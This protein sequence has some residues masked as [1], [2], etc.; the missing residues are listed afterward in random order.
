MSR[1]IRSKHLLAALAVVAMAAG[2]TSAQGQ[3]NPNLPATYGAIKLKAGFTPDPIAKELQAGGEIRTDLGGVKAHVAMAPDFSVDYAAG[4][5]PLVFRVKSVG[6]T[7]LLVNLPD[8]TW[9]ADDD[10]GGGLDPMIRIAQP[11]SGRYDIYVGTFKKEILDAT[12]FISERDLLKKPPVASNPNLPECHVVSAGVDNYRTQ[13]K[14][15]GCLNDAR[16]TAAAF[17]AQTGTVFRDV[18]VRLLLDE[19]ASHGAIVKSFQELTRQGAAGDTM[20]LFLSG[21][22]ARTNGNKGPTWF[23]LP[24]DFEPRQFV[25]TA[26]TD[27]QILDIADQLASQKKNVA[28]IIDACFVGQLNATAQPYLQRYQTPNQ[29][30]IMLML[31]SSATQESTALGNYSAY[32]KAFADS[33]AGAGDLNRDAKIT[34]GEMQLYTKKRTSDLLLAARNKNVQDPIVTWSPSLSKDTVVAYADK[35]AAVKTPVAALPTETP[36]RFAGEE[37]LA[38]YGNLSFAMYSNGRVVMADAKST[39]HGI[40]RQHGTQFTLSFSDGAVVYTGTLDGAVL[41]GTA[42]SPSSRQ[43]AVQTWQWKVRQAG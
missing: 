7:T 42:T 8:G 39:T 29:G 32:A 19:Q 33:M 9:V 43:N 34:L 18:K 31:S 41:S 2:R 27:K 13:N 3:P 24:V 28:L 16:N 38:G 23:F 12:L 35:N 22:G 37:T 21:H 36:R 10:S 6:D 5:Y 26:L 25:N 20:V 30:G 4:K 17:Q 14:L 40:W 1:L 15:S 11:K